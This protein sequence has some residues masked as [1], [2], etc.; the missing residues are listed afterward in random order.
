MFSKADLQR[1][2]DYTV[3]ANH[4]VLRAAATLS[5]DDFKR[6][7]GN[8]HGGVRG[9]LT[10]TMGAEWI[11]LERWKG[12]SPTRG[13]DEGEFPTVLELRERWRVIEDHR[14]SWLES[15]KE[16]A[17]GDTIA[18]TTLDGRPFESVLWTLVQHVANHSTYHRGQVLT[19]LRQLG[20]KPV[21]TD[22]VLWDRE[23]AS[24]GEK[25]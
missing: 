21:S 2:L 4:R 17:V 13:I 11:W 15:L 5:P 22:M 3:W 20:A 8:S 1:L 14:A 25:S 19:L 6:D 24:G 12:M 10:H 18:Y 9:T 16:S 23:T 7:L